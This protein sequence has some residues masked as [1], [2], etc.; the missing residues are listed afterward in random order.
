M[1][2]RFQYFS[3]NE[4]FVSLKVAVTKVDD[5]PVYGDYHNGPEYNIAVDNNSHY[6]DN[7][8]GWEGAI[9]TDRNHHY[10]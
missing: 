9:V 5:N 1:F 2:V 7:V 6:S 4:I 3:V 8:P 10:E